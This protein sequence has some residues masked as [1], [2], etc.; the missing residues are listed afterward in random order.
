[1]GF[2]CGPPRALGGRHGGLL[3]VR[4]K[5]VGHVATEGVAASELRLGFTIRV[6]NDGG[7]QGFQA[8]LDW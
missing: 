3:R 8:R 4:L 6:V 2:G 1:M 5:E 7:T